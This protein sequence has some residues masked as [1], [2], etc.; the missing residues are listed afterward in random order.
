MNCSGHFAEYLHITQ[1]LLAP[2]IPGPVHF[3]RKTYDDGRPP[4]IVDGP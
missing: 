3:M 2:G 1:R 4:L